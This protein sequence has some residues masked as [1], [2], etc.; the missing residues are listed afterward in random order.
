MFLHFSLLL[1]GQNVAS[2]KGR[3]SLVF[4]WLENIVSGSSRVEELIRCLHDEAVLRNGAE[5][6]S[7]DDGDNLE[8]TAKVS[9]KI[10]KTVLLSGVRHSGL[11]EKQ[12]D[13]VDKIWVLVGGFKELAR[14]CLCHIVKSVRL[15][16]T[17]LHQS[18]LS[19]DLIHGEGE[20]VSVLVYRVDKP[21][22]KE[23]LDCHCRLPVVN[24]EV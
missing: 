8:H 2:D 1:S 18:I 19:L 15:T 16:L 24:E 6:E 9:E 3:L 7:K 22:S 13:A 23:L 5:E 4:L 17:E 11:P 10:K 12:T 21:R 20:K 14:I